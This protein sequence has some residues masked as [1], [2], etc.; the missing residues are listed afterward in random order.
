[1]GAGLAAWRGFALVVAIIGLVAGAAPAARAV[2]IQAVK[3]PG[4]I[5]A[6]LVEDHSLPVVTID[7]AFRGGAA[8][9]PESKTGLASLVCDLLDE[10]AGE[11]DSSAFQ[12]RLEDLGTYLSV[13]AGEDTVGVSLRTVTASVA[14][15]FDLLRLALTA[16]RFDAPAVAR[17]KAQ[18][19]AELAHDAR[20]PRAIAGRQWREAEFG[21]HPYARR[22]SGTEA[23]VAAITTNDL[24]GFVRDRLAKD[25]M[26]VAVVGDIAPEALKALLDKT[27]GGLPAQATPGTVPPL[28]VNTSGELLLAR[29]AIP[30]S[31]VVFG[32]PGLKRDDPDWYAALLVND[33]LGGGG[34]SSRLTQEVRDK[35]GLAY[36]VYSGLD[37]MQEGGVI[38]GGVATENASVAQSI[39]IIRAEWQRMRAEGPSAKELADA[40]T[41]LT[42]SFPLGL[43]ST[44]RIAGTLVEMERD[45]LGID[46]LDRRSALIDGVTLDD[47][48]R[49]AQRLLDPA[50]L[51]FVVVGAPSDLE[52]AREVPARGN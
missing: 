49:V 9:D 44:G 25:V 11:L 39:E 24:R 5:T 42:G 30:Q 51:T 13:A 37:P 18:V 7:L 38:I 4:G 50:A 41:Y 27:F 1:M 22:V 33:V 36:S 12:G 16:P 3:S 10:G 46:Y 45:R 52:G 31:V 40:K 35:R 6:W 23:G 19:L 15:A 17:V 43:D 29:L 34:F 8:L 14:P 21:D 28:R 2:T 26:L 48:K 47:A 32:Q 20:Q